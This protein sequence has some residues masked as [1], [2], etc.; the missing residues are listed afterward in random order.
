MHA[1]PTV[2]FLKL[3]LAY[4]TCLQCTVQYSTEVAT[5]RRRGALA[6]VGTG[7]LHKSTVVV[8]GDRDLLSAAPCMRPELAP[9]IVQRRLAFLKVGTVRRSLPVA[10]ATRDNDQPGLTEPPRGARGIIGACDQ[11]Q[12]DRPRRRLSFASGYLCLDF[13]LRS[14]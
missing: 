2:L 14:I 8:L 13:L 9:R 7:H 4:L 12:A 11:V 6:A 3:K 5:S 10:S 1:Y